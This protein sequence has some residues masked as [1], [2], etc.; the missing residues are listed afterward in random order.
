[1]P[2]FLKTMGCLTMVAASVAG[3][4]YSPEINAQGANMTMTANN[5]QSV[6]LPRPPLKIPMPLDKAGYKIDVTFEVPPLPKGKTH[7]N[8]FLGLRVLFAP[9]A[10]KV[11]DALDEYP[12]S[13]RISLFR[14]EGDREIRLP[15][16]NRMRRPG[17]G[18]PPRRG[19]ALEIPEGGE[20]I[21]SLD[22]AEHSGAPRGTPDASTLV[23]GFAS[24]IGDGIP[25]LYRLQAETLENIPALSDVTSFFAYE[26]LPKR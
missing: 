6:T 9:G 26:E 3:A 13:A 11:F 20:V 24:A 21:A 25:G 8:Y 17:P 22:H 12:V 4:G 10:D 18:Q 2:I 14:I 5:E 19:E 15:L 1:M 16:F 7:F 23:L